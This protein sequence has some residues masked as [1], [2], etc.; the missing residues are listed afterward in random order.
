M[1]EDHAPR[2]IGAIG[3]AY[4]GLT[5][6][7]SDGKPYW[8]IQCCLGEDWEEISEDLY[9]ALIRWEDT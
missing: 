3:N 2:D 8:C 1:I 5:V 7:R 6:K 4:G 9:S